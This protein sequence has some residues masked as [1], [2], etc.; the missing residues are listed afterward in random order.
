M[1]NPP[2]A[3]R[4]NNTPPKTL[5]HQSRKAQQ[6][7]STATFRSCEAGRRSIDLSTHLTS[8]TPHSISAPHPALPRLRGARPALCRRYARLR[9]HPLCGRHG[10]GIPGPHSTRRGHGCGHE[11]KFQRGTGC[12]SGS[13]RQSHL[14]SGPHPPPTRRHTRTTRPHTCPHTP[15]HLP[16]HLP[17]KRIHVQGGWPNL[18]KCCAHRQR[19]RT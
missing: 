18:D 10:T 2:E 5:F 6:H 3:N 12:S 4:R 7:C 13:L 15:P 17:P 8:T 11:V 14:V 9:R 1:L 16:P 19:A